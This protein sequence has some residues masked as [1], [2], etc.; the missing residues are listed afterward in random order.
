M[1]N[2]DTKKVHKDLFFTFGVIPEKQMNKQRHRK[3]NLLVGG[4]NILI[5]LM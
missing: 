3:H 2:Y 1:Q 4:N 5:T